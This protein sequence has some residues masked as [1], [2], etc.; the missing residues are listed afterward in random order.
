[1]NLV[2]SQ[3]DV[4]AARGAGELEPMSWVGADASATDGVIERSRGHEYCLPEA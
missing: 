4:I 3:E 2:M 1:M